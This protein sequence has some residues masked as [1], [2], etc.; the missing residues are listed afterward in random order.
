MPLR[1]VLTF[2]KFPANSGMATGGSLSIYSLWSLWLRILCKRMRRSLFCRRALVLVFVAFLSAQFSFGWGND[3]HKMI[4]QVAIEML[5]SNVDLP[6]FLRTPKSFEEMEYL[7]P[8]PDRWRSS[9]EPELS[10]AQAPDHFIDLELADLASPD[11]L[12]ER[13]FDFVRDLYDAQVRDPTLA[14]KLTPQSVGLLPWQANED[15]E[16]LKIDMREYRA[17]LVAHKAVD[18][19]EQAILYDAGVLGHYVADG[20][21]P[22]HTTIN[23]NGWVEAKNPENFTRTRG[24]HSKFETG[25]V[26]ENMRVPDIQPLVP[27]TP[28]LLDSPFQDFV[29]YL[30]ANHLQVAEVYRV[31]KVGGFEGAG[32]AQSRSFTAE[33]MAA[34]AA[35]LRDMIYTAWVESG[36]TVPALRDHSRR[37]NRHGLN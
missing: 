32:T 25:F 33:R 4:N 34:G 1:F 8:E 36:Q 14:M 29:V 9:A 30:R 11:G 16:R 28:R 23:Y 6:A 15:F 10:A 37:N 26:H 3:A 5:P 31:E 13:R 21:Q 22:L 20:S 18:G 17:R 35:M 12:P 2:C 27:A 19:A 24:I 7:G